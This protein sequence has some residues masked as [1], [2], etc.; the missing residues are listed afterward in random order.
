MNAR[1][2]GSGAETGSAGCGEALLQAPSLSHI[3]HSLI[4]FRKSTPQ[5]NRQINISIS[6]SK[7]QV[8]DFVR[9]LTL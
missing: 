4:T 6:N 1:P 3:M 7:Q 9:E 5:Q 8:D 2:D